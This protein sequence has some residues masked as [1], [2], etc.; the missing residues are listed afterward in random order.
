MF[1]IFL[2]V[3]MFILITMTEH[4]RN[5]GNMMKSIP[6]SPW[7]RYGRF[8]HDHY[9]EIFATDMLPEHNDA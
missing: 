5:I 9:P 7:E 1:E 3:I 6:I 4:L 2:N 8:K